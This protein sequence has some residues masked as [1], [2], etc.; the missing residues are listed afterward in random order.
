MRRPLPRASIDTRKRLH[1]LRLTD[2]RFSMPWVT[3]LLLLSAFFPMV[4]AFACAPTPGAPFLLW[5]AVP[6]AVAGAA[7]ANYLHT[8]NHY[9]VIKREALAG[10]CDAG[11]L[12]HHIIPY[13]RPVPPLKLG[14]FGLVGGWAM[15]ILFSPTVLEVR[16]ARHM[17]VLL[18]LTLALIIVLA[19]LDYQH[20]ERLRTR[21]RDP[22]P[23]CGYDLQASPQRCPECGA[24]RPLPRATPETMRLLNVRDRHLKAKS[25]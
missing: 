19:T 15:V 7:T 17:L 20:L 22:C 4:C 13:H 21:P 16:E 25:H 3:P 6:A 10:A 9:R 5:L 24:T 11:P 14:R 12:K 1:A 23:M 18:L 2:A 8:L